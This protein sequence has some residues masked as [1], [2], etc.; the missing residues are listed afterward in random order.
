MRRMACLAAGAAA[1]L[2][3]QPC[4]AADDLRDRDMTERRSG[5]FAGLSLNF[6][7]GGAA[8]QKASA[9]LQLS[10]VHQL[11]SAQGVTAGARGGEGLALGFD[12]G[13]ELSYRVGGREVSK[14]G[15]RLNAKGSTKWIVI[16]G[17]IVLGVIILAAFAG[18]Q[19]TPGPHDDAF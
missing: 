12:S 11:T 3:A 13:G 2:G 5:A 7:L 18:A 14:V 4:L 8:G 19:P 1:M 17:V 6:P 16:G 15:E 10:P 9:R